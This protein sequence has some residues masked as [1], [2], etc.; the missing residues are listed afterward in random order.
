MNER[1]DITEDGYR[2]LCDCY[3][4]LCLTCFEFKYSGCEGDAEGYPC[5]ECGDNNVVGIE[6]ALLIGKLNFI[7]DG[8]V[9]DEN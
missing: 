8:G 5:E 2:D 6:T 9:L 7:D 1:K 3:G 4:G